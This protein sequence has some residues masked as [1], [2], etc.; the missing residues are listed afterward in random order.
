VRLDVERGTVQQAVMA[1]GEFAGE[2]VPVRKRG[3]TTDA[4]AWLL[5]VVLDA[6]RGRSE[7]RILDGED[8]TAPPVA[9]AVVPHLIPFGFHG[10]FAG[11][12]AVEAAAANRAGQVR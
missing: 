7:L 2:C 10:N 6:E 8:L 11:A 1:P 3:A 5:T 9:R 12:A 4:A